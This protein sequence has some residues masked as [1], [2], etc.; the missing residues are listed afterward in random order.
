[1]E[2]PRILRRRH[3][4]GDRPQRDALHPIRRRQTALAPAAQDWREAAYSLGILKTGYLE[5]S[6]ETWDR[7]S[8][9]SGSAR[10]TRFVVLTHAQ[11]SW[12]KRAP[13][14]AEYGDERGAIPLDEVTAVA[15]AG[16]RIEVFDGRGLRRW[17]LCIDGKT[18]A[19][20]DAI[21]VARQARGR[22]KPESTPA[23][24]ALILRT[25]PEKRVL[26]ERRAAYGVAAV[27]KPPS[28]G[29]TRRR[30]GALRCCGPRAT[31]R[32]T[33]RIS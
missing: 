24:R 25:R 3:T 32:S 2:P 19:W 5:T 15:Q 18:K 27:V 10:K 7:L 1:M 33:R 11:L 29:A 8:A 22:K 21:D 28:A 30:R 31:C 20:R 4:F 23:P 16:E 12:F 26:V 17:F 14:D 13:G 9:R 6:A